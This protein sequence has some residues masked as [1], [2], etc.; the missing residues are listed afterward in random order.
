MTATPKL[1]YS[2]L[3]F[4]PNW[5]V[6]Q[7]PLINDPPP[8]SFNIEQASDALELYMSGPVFCGAL[9]TLK[10]PIDLTKPYVGL[11]LEVFLDEVAVKLWR[12]CEMD[13]K[14][15]H[16][17]R[18]FNWSSQ[19]NQGQ[20]QMD[21]I[22]RTWTPIGLAI[23]V[24]QG[25]QKYSFRY[26]MDPTNFVYSYLSINGFTLPPTFQHLLCPTDSWADT[27]NIQLQPV[28]NGVAG[29]FRFRYRNI[30]LT[31]CAQSF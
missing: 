4:D 22:S 27:L 12:C 3:E 1:I 13:V 29:A 17:G 16:A 31:Q 15:A 19:N 8:T 6:Q 9:A 21:P 28:N 5:L 24:Y 23:P 18:I 25:W 7:G 20:M 10:L 30:T 2:N 26:W 14:G 11:D